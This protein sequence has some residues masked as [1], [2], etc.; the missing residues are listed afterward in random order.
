MP[1]TKRIKFVE[2][3]IILSFIGTLIAAGGIINIIFFVQKPN[4]LFL[5]FGVLILW[6]GLF[7]FAWP[8]VRKIE[9]M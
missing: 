5:L 2:H 6:L 1:K 9:L 8:I 4:L 3:E 7:I